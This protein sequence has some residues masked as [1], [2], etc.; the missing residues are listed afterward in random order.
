MISRRYYGVVM[1]FFLAFFNA[2]TV[3]IAMVYANTGKFI[4]G[5]ICISTLE[6]TVIA[7]VTALLIPAAPFG[8]RVAKKRFN[9]RDGSL[10]F[11]LI[12]TIPV[13]TMMVLVLTFIFALINVG[14][15]SIFFMAWILSIPIAFIVS[16]ITSIIMTPFSEILT[17]SIIK[18]DENKLNTNIEE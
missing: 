4:I 11:L 15:S 7:L 16:Y 2:I 5:A 1:S 17:N 13:C 18:N 3:S 8:I 14:I 12:S 9:A 6:A 10:K